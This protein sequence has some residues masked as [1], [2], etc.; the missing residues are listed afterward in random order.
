M[1]VLLVE[2]EPKRSWGK[3]NQYVGL[4]KIANYHRQQGDKVEYIVSPKKPKRINNPDLIYVTSLFT[5]WYDTA[6]EAVEIYKRNFPSAKVMLGG[7]YASICPDHAKKSGADEVMAGQHPGA[8]EL[9]P[10]PSV[11]PYRQDFV[12][13]F[14]SWGCNRSC[15]YCATHLLY[16][17]GIRQRDPE[18]VLDDISF[19]KD[20]GYKTLYIGD[21]NLLYN[22]AEH[23]DKI[24]EKI[25]KR[26]MKVEIHLPGG[27]AAKDFTQETAYKMRDAGFKE[28]S[29][30]L[31]STDATVLKKMG[32]AN[33]TSKEDLIQ[34]LEMADKAGFERHN[35]NVYF[36]IGLPYQT[37]PDMVDTLFFLIK[38][39]V[40]AHPHRLTPI[41]HTVD[42][43]R[44]GLENW[45]YRD[46]YYK[47]F[48]AP[49]QTNFTSKDL[50]EIYKIA[51]FFSVG[52]RFTSGYKWLVTESLVG[53]SFRESIVEDSKQEK[54]PAP[55][56][57]TDDM[58]EDEREPTKE[59]ME[60]EE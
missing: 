10:D 12:Y 40:W 13:I 19:L 48:L 50:N 15:T 49:G 52:Q 56:E 60:G 46:L 24:C 14:T 55:E 5:Y 11:L 57:A 8:H 30:A 42:W 16:G 23:I 37:V 1:N 51:R 47:D 27:M 28:I 35:S 39:G 25:I 6:W 21:D 20:K 3:N 7:I 9:P 32:R 17:K 41:P 31:E 45:D 33:N 44:M 38:A 4:L 54:G 58:A 22:S 53:R 2:P 26:N 18:L 59:E 36:I 34:A 29:F 43:K